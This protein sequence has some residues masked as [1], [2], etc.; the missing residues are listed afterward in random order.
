MPRSAMSTSSRIKSTTPAQSLRRRARSDSPRAT[1]FFFQQAGNQ[2]LFVQATPSGTKRATGVTNAGTIRAAAAE[3]KAAGG[4]AYALA[5]NNTGV[6]AATGYKKVNGQVYLTSDGG[7]I[8]NSGKISREA[9]QRQ[10]RHDRAHRYLLHRDEVS[11]H[12]YEFR[13][14]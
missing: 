11:K 13:Y 8:S 4:N 1:R 9:S 12:R 7:S 10:R 6:I 14:A 3:L 2:H 5:I